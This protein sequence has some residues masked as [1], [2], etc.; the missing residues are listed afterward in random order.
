MRIIAES[1]EHYLE[2]EC[3]DDADLDGTFEM[4]TEDGE[5]L[6]VNGWMFV[7]EVL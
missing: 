7:I 6:L 3:S 4:V 1:P 5:T 2:G